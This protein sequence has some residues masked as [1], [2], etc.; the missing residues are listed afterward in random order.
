LQISIDE[1]IFVEKPMNR[2][3]RGKFPGSQIES[4]GSKIYLKD[5]YDVLGTH[6]EEETFE[7]LCIQHITK[8]NI[9][10]YNEIEKNRAYMDKA[11]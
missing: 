10:N 4:N 9:Y 2:L 11:L 8:G 3:Y 5:E 6:L 1:D 7:A